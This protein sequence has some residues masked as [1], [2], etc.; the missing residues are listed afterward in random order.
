MQKV[1]TQPKENKFIEI[2]V[3]VQLH[4]LETYTCIFCLLFNLLI[5]GL[6]ILL[7]TY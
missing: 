5:S 3:I 1:S 6:H 4:I 2:F 7:Y